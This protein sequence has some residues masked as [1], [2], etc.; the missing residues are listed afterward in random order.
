MDAQFKIHSVQAE[1]ITPTNNLLDFDIPAGEVYDFTKSYVSI[2]ARMTG[3]NAQ[4]NHA[5][6]IFNVG[7]KSPFNSND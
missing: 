4:A 1:N 5:N 6:A 2:N 3:S 7:G